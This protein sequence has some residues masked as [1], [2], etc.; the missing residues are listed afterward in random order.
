MVLST[1]TYEGDKHCKV[2]H[3]PSLYSIE[4][5]APVDNHGRGQ[6]FSPTDL[7]GAAI[8][9]CALT[10]MSIAAEKDG[11]NIAGATAKV[12]KTMS[13]SPRRVAGLNVTITM[14]AGIP[15]DYRS[16]LETIANNCP[17]KLSLHPEVSAPM[18]FSWL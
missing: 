11:V 1:A 6:R 9:A 16:K 14:P 3:G 12:E 10:V 8:G 5:D 13:S 15:V 17:V 4:T 7:M 2:V 18:I